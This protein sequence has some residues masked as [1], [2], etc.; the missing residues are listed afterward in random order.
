MN[1]NLR[2]PKILQMTKMTSIIN[3]N[4]IIIII[5]FLYSGVVGRIMTVGKSNSILKA[6]Y[7][8][9]LVGKICNFFYPHVLFPLFLR[10]M[11]IQHCY[12]RPGCI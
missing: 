2:C 10:L 7:G 8:G 11:N 12:T 1:L 6:R 3:K 5:R 9:E 4:Y